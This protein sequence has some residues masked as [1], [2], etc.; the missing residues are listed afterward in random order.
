MARRHVLAYNSHR[1]EARGS[2]PRVPVHDAAGAPAARPRSARRAPRSAP[3]PGAP[4]AREARSGS[5]HV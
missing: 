4:R 3:R 1:G 5:S 2:G